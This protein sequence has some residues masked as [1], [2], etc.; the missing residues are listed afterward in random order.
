M[1]DTTVKTRREKYDGQIFLDHADGYYNC[2]ES[3]TCSVIL[4]KN[5]KPLKGVRA[6]MTAKW[7]S[8]IIRTEEFITTGEAVQFSFTGTVPGWIYFGFE[9]LDAAGEPLSGPGVFKHRMK[10]TI[11]T[12]IGAIFDADKIVSCVRKPADFDEFWAKR[13]QE[14]AAMLPLKAE[15]RELNTKTPG[16]RLFAVSVS[17]PRGITATGYL[18]YP[19]EAAPASLKAGISFQSLTYSDTVR[20]YAVNMAKAGMLGFSTTWHGFPVS[21]SIQFYRNNVPQYFQRGF[22]GIGDRERWVYGDIFFRVLG[23]L[24][25]IKGHPL[26][27]GRDLMVTGGS[28]GGIQTIFAAAIEPRT[29]LALIAVPSSCECN[30]FE[31]GR[32]PNGPFRRIPVEEL[33]ERPELIEAG[34]YYDSVNFAGNIRCESFVCTGFTDEACCPSNVYAF[35]NAIPETTEKMMTTNPKTGHYYTTKDP[36]AA[37]RFQGFTGVSAQPADSK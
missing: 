10:P 20:A 21:K 1:K 22:A 16:I 19:E 14:V 32:N 34:F 27:N 12:E 13:R 15:Y 8:R 17:V 18:A 25:F 7:E 9:I 24:E 37:A 11:V 36:R 3:V 29:T 5:R 23:E 2:G 30:A 4:R 35:Y 33:R 6:R 31:A 28:L 26:W